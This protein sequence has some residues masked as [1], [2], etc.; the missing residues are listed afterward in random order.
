MIENEIQILD[1]QPIKDAKFFNFDAYAEALSRIIKREET[2][3]PLVVGIFGE[4]GSGKTS[5][6]KTLEQNIIENKDGYPAQTIWFNAWKFDKEDAIWRALLMRVLEELKSEAKKEYNEDLKKVLD[7]L[8]TSLYHEVYREE[9]GTLTFDWGKAAK[10]TFKLGISVLPVIGGNLTKLVEK[11]ANE[12][13][14]IN[15]I[16]DSLQREKKTIN[17][18]KVQFLEEFQS[19]FEKIIDEHYVKKNKRAVIFIDDLDRCIPEKAIEVLEAIKLFLDAKGCIFILGIDR[20]VISQGVDIK[21]RDFTIGGGKIPISGD[22]YL[23][24]IIQLSFM[25]PPIAPKKLEAFIKGLK[26][27]VEFYEPYL[28][29]IIKGIGQNPRKIKRFINAIEFQRNLADLIPEIK[30]HVTTPELKESFTALL[31]EWQILSNSSNIEYSDFRKYVSRKPELLLKMHEYLG[32]EQPGEITKELS[33]FSK[34]ESLQEL[35]NAF[36]KKDKLKL[37]GIEEIIRQVIHLS[38]VT[39]TKRI[40]ETEEEGPL[41][42]EKVEE[43]IRK[44]MSLEGKDLSGIDLRGFTL[45]GMNLNGVILENANLSKTDLSE[46][47]LVGANLRHADLSGATLLK[48]DLSKAKLYFTILNHA[49]LSE[50]ILNNAILSGTHL[51]NATL[52]KAD[53]TTAYLSGSDFSYAKL[54]GAKLPGGLGGNDFTGVDFSEVDLSNTEL[55]TKL[56][57]AI[58][59][60][61]DLSHK[62]FEGADLSNAK[63]REANLFNAKLM[64][65]NLSNANFSKATL[66]DADFSD[67]NLEHT[68]FFEAKLINAYFCDSTLINVKLLGADLSDARL[69]ETKTTGVEVNKETRAAG[70]TLVR[71]EDNQD[72]AKIKRALD[73]INEELRDIILRDNER[74]RNIYS[75]SKHTSAPPD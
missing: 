21:Y 71:E 17:I 47:R 28:G 11:S 46:A 27:P 44:G 34:N 5:L 67:A 14:A 69:I 42:R 40:I 63:L 4:W 61:R 74:Y 45:K 60:G 31:I 20:R 13:E 70:V 8:Q 1:D 75:G 33:P 37:D 36:P 2:N 62:S 23:E 72:E 19:R 41:T 10:G 29:M 22:D 73:D 50:A 15:N 65:A 66:N 52:Y 49:D 54:S 24:K 32:S 25:L 56:S 35:I 6:M 58:L 57:G 7:D 59:S 9:L 30:E 68:N 55:G 43:I 53:L 12:K 16:L 51:N 39:E 38:S 48:T 18:E 26:V 3:T 64:R